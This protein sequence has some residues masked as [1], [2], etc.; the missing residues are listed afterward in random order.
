MTASPG[1][2]VSHSS[3]PE[4]GRGPALSPGERLQTVRKE[5]KLE[6]AAVAEQLNLSPGVVRALEADNYRTLPNATFVKGY[7]RSYARVL[8]ISS[9]DLI[10]GYEALTERDKPVVVEPVAPP[11]I[12]EPRHSLKYGF[13]ALLV[14]GLL[15][16]VLWLMPGEPERTEPPMAIVTDPAALASADAGDLDDKVADP[17][18]AGTAANTDAGMAL[19]TPEASISAPAATESTSPAIPSTTTADSMPAL[20]TSEA[21]PIV[22]VPPPAADTAAPVA[23]PETPVATET[24]AVTPEPGRGLLKLAFSGDCWVEVRDARGK[25]AFSALKRAGDDVTLSVAIPLS[26]KLGNGDVVAVTFNGQPVAFSTTPSRKVI[27]LTLGG[28]D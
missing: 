3:P 1:H 27:R 10:R 14:A 22:A 8:G 24:P 21:P 18:A 16:L 6:I 20:T 23:T 28:A 4:H 17:E 19:V 25:M 12:R 11:K 2:P 15:A 7:L 26:V 13:I 5:R 9:D